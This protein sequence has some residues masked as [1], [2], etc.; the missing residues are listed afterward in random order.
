MSLVLNNDPQTVDTSTAQGIKTAN[1]VKDQQ[2]LEAQ[3]ALE[4]ISSAS[5]ETALQ[6]VGNSGHNINIKV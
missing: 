5:L 2:A 3:M 6:P 1:I 4:L